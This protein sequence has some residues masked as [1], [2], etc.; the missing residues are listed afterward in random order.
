MFLL[1][2]HR[3]AEKKSPKGYD[4]YVSLSTDV[5][6]MFQFI[7]EGDQKL[8]GVQTMTW[9]AKKKKK[10]KKKKIKSQSCSSHSF[11]G[12]RLIQKNSS[13]WFLI[14]FLLAYFFFQF[15]MNLLVK[16]YMK[17]YDRDNE[18]LWTT[19]F[20]NSVFCLI[21]CSSKNQIKFLILYWTKSCDRL[22]SDTSAAQKK[23]NKQTKNVK[24]PHLG[25]V[26]QS[27]T[28][29]ETYNLFF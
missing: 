8:L 18:T 13:F 2:T 27:L 29:F 21:S 20:F 14:F 7:A 16:T 15:V 17:I 24:K 26:F 28:S 5:P 9:K 25:Q 19:D 23:T 22:K 3:V 10:K 1:S 11:F 4:L 6:C 12:A